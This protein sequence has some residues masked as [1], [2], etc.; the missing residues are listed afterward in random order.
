MPK[1][2]ARVLAGDHPPIVLVLGDDLRWTCKRFPE[3]ARDCNL[4]AG[5]RIGCESS[6]EPGYAAAAEIAQMLKGRVDYGPPTVTVLVS[7]HGSKIEIS[8]RAESEDGGIVGDSLK[9]IRPGQ[10]CL[11]RPYAHSRQLG[12]GRHEILDDEEE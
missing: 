5:D 4:L 10:T 7:V 1:R 12:P 6:G 9:V 11:G 3:L 8:Q 2:I